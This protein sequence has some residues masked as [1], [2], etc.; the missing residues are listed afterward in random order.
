MTE[1]RSQM[2]ATVLL[3]RGDDGDEVQVGDTLLIL[4]S[5]KMEIPVAATAQG[6]VTYCVEPG[7]SVERG[8]LLARLR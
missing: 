6:T 7:Q 5:M 4:E 8:A 3:L 1:I 2:A